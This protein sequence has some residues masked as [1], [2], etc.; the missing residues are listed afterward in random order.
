MKHLKF[1]P[2]VIV[3][4]MT[5]ASC[6]TMTHSMREPLVRFDLNAHDMELSAPVTGTATCV[7]VLGIDWQRLFSNTSASTGIYVIGDLLNS[8]VAPGSKEYAVY[9]M[10]EK[11]PGW[12][13]VVYP[14]YHSEN[15]RFW[16]LGLIYSKTTTTVTARMG[17]LKK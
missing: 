8:T 1:L 16:G 3:A 11:N 2:L 12:D 15:H 10:I 6:S 13:F 7:R 5:F 17:R 4:M 14:Q 9:D